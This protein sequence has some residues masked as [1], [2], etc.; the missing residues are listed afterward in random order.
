MLLCENHTAPVLSIWFMKDV[1]DKF[2]T[3]SE[4]G[5]IRLWDSNNYSVTARCTAPQAT[6]ATLYPVCAVFTDEVILSGWSDG[7]IRA[8]R[9]D[10]C[11]LLWQIDNAHKN[12]V[13][14]IELAGNCKFLCSGGM[15]G[16]IRVWEIRSRELISHLKEHNSRVTKI[17]LFP[18]DTHLL[19]CARDKSILCWDLKAEKR[20][21]AQSQRMG[22]L[23]CFAMSPLDN[24]KYI[25]VGQERRITY[26][27]LRK[28][29]AEAVLDSSPFKGES[30]EL[31]TVTISHN[32]K[33]FAVGGALGVLRLY[34]FSTG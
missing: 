30:E 33:Y 18:D 20:V 2:I 21:S 27:D 13:T 29:N 15:E 17:K 3:C 11:Q 8:F 4:D 16:D 31:N 25:S 5:T 23:N 26:W 19:S 14:A 32:N 24:N 28:V 22:G 34:E 10:N 9:I 7:K 12:G 6:S 1:S